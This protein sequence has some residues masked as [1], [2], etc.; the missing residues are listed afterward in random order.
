M[1]PEILQ[2]IS[3][4]LGLEQKPKKVIFMERVGLVFSSVVNTVIVQSLHQ[5]PLSIEDLK[6][7]TNSRL[8]DLG[9]KVE[10]YQYTPVDHRA[11]RKHLNSL[12]K[13]RVVTQ[14]QDR[15]WFLTEDGEEVADLLIGK[16]RTKEQQMR[17]LFETFGSLELSKSTSKSTSGVDNRCNL[18]LK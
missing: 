12:A 4:K 15:K 13:H 2:N 3:Q 18:G 6:S 10:E 14:E 1:L 17:D 7:L 5:E 8:E 9:R 11:L 16:P